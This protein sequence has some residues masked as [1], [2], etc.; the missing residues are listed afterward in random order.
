[1][2]KIIAFEGASDDL[3]EIEGDDKYDELGHTKSKPWTAVIYDPASSNALEVS[4]WYGPHGTWHT[5]VGLF[6][7][8]MPWPKWPIKIGQ[9][10]NTNYSSRLEIEVPDGAYISRV[11]PKPDDD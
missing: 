8:D 3:I 7:E 10:L 1:M 4:V 2:T 11:L 5:G 9:S 6:D